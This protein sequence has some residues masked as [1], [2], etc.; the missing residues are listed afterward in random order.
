MCMKKWWRIGAFI[1]GS[2]LIASFP[3]YAQIP[4]FYPQSPMYGQPFW[5]QPYA[6]QPSYPQYPSYSPSPWGEPQMGYSSYGYSPNQLYQCGLQ[7]VY[8]RRYHDAIRTFQMFLQM[9]PQSSLADNA[10]YWTGECYYAQKRYYD[11]LSY[12]QRIL[13]ECPRAN[14]VPDALLKIAL[15]YMS[16][17]QHARGC[18]YLADLVNR[19]PN[20]EPAQKAYRWFDRCGWHSSYY[21][22]S[23]FQAP[24]YYYNDWTFPK[25][26]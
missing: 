19:Y 10:L 20:S 5:S 17:N 15:S 9:Y 1:L 11:A 7:L 8:A 14:K 3:L 22:G 24:D 2:L 18:Q 6:I 16:L 21:R 12:F 23:Q 25:N 13:Y 26:Y 4:G